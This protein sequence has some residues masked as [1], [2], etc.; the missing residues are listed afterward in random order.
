MGSFSSK[1][2]RKCLRIIVGTAT[3]IMIIF[4]L[5]WLNVL[6][7]LE[8]AQIYL[9]KTIT[10]KYQRDCCC[11]FLSSFNEHLPSFL[12]VPLMRWLVVVREL[13]LF[14]YSVLPSVV[15]NSFRGEC[16]FS[17]PFNLKTTETFFHLEL[18]TRIRTAS[19]LALIR[20]KDF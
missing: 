17:Q 11:F 4:A 3:V 2:C 19:F 20:Y 1:K 16:G 15:F 5:F 6:N 13:N 14:S 7:G 12:R 9:S 10:V 18:A 8:G